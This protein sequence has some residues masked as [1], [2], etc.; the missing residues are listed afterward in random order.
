MS[1]KDI[2]DIA[3]RIGRMIIRA[4][5]EDFCEQMGD[6]LTTCGTFEELQEIIESYME[7]Q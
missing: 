4:T 5:I 6:E 3:E 1:G 2:E 7:K